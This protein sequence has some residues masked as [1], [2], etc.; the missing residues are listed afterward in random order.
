MQQSNV[1]GRADRCVDICT[2]MNMMYIS[3]CTCKEVLISNQETVSWRWKQQSRLIN[4][5]CQTIIHLNVF[6]LFLESDANDPSVKMQ[7]KAACGSGSFSIV[8]QLGRDRDSICFEIIC[9][10]ASVDS[11][12]CFIRMRKNRESV[13]EGS[14]EMIACIS[15]EG[16]PENHSSGGI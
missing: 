2:Y 9:W 13:G 4:S 5:L 7:S 14:G 3:T 10:K 8:L 6:L 12:L 16:A 1:C 15:G 11:V